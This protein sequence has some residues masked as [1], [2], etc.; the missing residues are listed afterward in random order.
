MPALA[1]APTTAA[2]IA[3]DEMSGTDGAV[4]AAYTGLKNWLGE[5]AADVLDHRRREA[6][7]LF[8][9]IGI[10]FAV[11]G[12]SEAQERLIPFD[13]LPRIIA[14]HEWATLARGLEQRVKTINFLIKDI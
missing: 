9:R 4:R 5:V 11:Y 10:T 6:E 14:R 8:R 7:L 2:P 3:F 12:E 13:V 1:Q